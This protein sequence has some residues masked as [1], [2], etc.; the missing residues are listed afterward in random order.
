[1]SL[2]AELNRLQ[3]RHG[4]LA[5]EPLRELARQLGLPLYRIQEVASFYPHFRLAPP[6]RSEVLLCRDL[7][8]FLAG[9]DTWGVKVKELLARQRGVEVRE[10]SCLGRCDRA[11]AAMVNGVAVAGEPAEHIARLALNAREPA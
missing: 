8:C 1:M 2:I 10:V 9:G 4:Y 7:S 3:A 11:P 5:E 6:P